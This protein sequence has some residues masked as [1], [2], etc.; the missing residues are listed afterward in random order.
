M[1]AY[2]NIRCRPGLVALGLA[3]LLPLVACGSRT[4]PPDMRHLPYRPVSSHDFGIP[5]QPPRRQGESQLW[6]D[7]DGDGY[8]EWFSS[9]EFRL[10]A[11]NPRLPIP[12]DYEWFPVP[13][14][15][16]LTRPALVMSGDFDLEGDGKRDIVAVAA[17]TVMEHF[18]VWVLDPATL[19]P[20]ADFLLDAP[21]GRFDD[22]HWDGGFVPLGGV[23][24]P[25]G[26]G[27]LIV[28]LV[29][30]RYDIE[31]RGVWAVDPRSGAI[32][33][34]YVT[35][36]LPSRIASTIA[37]L[38]GDGVPEIV[39][40][41]SAPGNLHGET[42]NGVSDDST[43]VF[44][45]NADGKE[46]WHHALMDRLAG[47]LVLIDD[48][49][50]DGETEVMVGGSHEVGVTGR[51]IMF[52]GN[53]GT[54]EYREELD[55]GVMRLAWLPRSDD[56]RARFAV[57]FHDGRLV[58]YQAVDGAYEP[59][60][61][62][63]FPT[64]IAQVLVSDVLGDGEPEITVLVSRRALV[65]LDLDL[66]PLAYV[67]VPTWP[68]RNEI[69]AWRMTPTDVRLLSGARPGE[70]IRFVAAPN[71]TPWAV[72]AAVSV[73]V[74]IGLA[75]QI[76]RNSRTSDDPVVVR[77]LRRQ[78]LDRLKILRHEK[79]GTLENLDRLVWY[80][81]AA[82]EAGSD[83]VA[84]LDA[85]RTLARDTQDTTLERLRGSVAIAERVGVPGHRVA[86]LAEACD[87][88]ETL[89][90]HVQRDLAVAEVSTALE[91]LGPLRQLL[92][93]QC[94]RLREVVE[95][96]FRVDLATVVADVLR[97]QAPTLADAGIAT[98]VQGEAVD[99]A[100]WQASTGPV[101]ICDPDDL[102]FI[103]DNLVG[104]AARA[105]QHMATRAL[106]LSWQVL[107]DAVLVHVSDTG[108]GIP[109]DD[110]DRV[111]AGD[112]TTR[113]GGG[114]GF[115]RTQESLRLFHGRLWI[116]SSRPGGGTVFVVRLT[117]ARGGAGEASAGLEVPRVRRKRPRQSSP[118][119]VLGGVVLLIAA[120][121]GVL[122]Y[123]AAH[124]RWTID[125]GTITAHGGVLGRT[126]W[127][128]EVGCKSARCMVAPWNHAE[129]LATWRDCDTDTSVVACLHRSTGEIIWTGRPD[130][131]ILDAA[132]GTEL[133][134]SG[135]MRAVGVYPC[136][137]DGDGESE[138]IAEFRHYP[139]FPDCL[140]RFDRHG[141]ALN[142]YVSSG[143]ILDIAITD[144][145]HDGKDEIIAAA[146]NNSP[147]Y[148][149]GS[150]FILDEDHFGGAAVDSLANPQTSVRDSAAYRIVVPHL[151]D[152]Y[153]ALIKEVRLGATNV[154]TFAGPSGDAEVSAEM[155]AT[156]DPTHRVFTY[157]DAALR[158]LRID[159]TDN[160]RAEVAALWPDSLQAHRG[161]ADPEWL[162]DWF[163]TSI[164]FVNG[165]MVPTT[166]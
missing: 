71:R 68:V 137:L 115:K 143:H 66:T 140:V 155:G 164:R 3:A 157:F 89:L 105:M 47:A 128:I 29:N 104:N 158:P 74:L 85:V 134:R 91:A 38:D 123:G 27:D 69:K 46:R 73:L 15:Y 144:I 126:L 90:T 64:N 97:A 93:L 11:R 102:G 133:V 145:D 118:F 60:H 153:M 139:Y 49:D 32:V 119:I 77:E 28:F 146:T 23:P 31:G 129:L 44:V 43:Y 142:Q 141:R 5:D 111:L 94:G 19:M 120:F 50:G 159:I 99:P 42:I 7:A 80:L 109:P 4:I 98:A 122:R 132:Y 110:W 62:R 45:V 124:A 30:S 40:G 131:S 14:P 36:A 59:V 116:E 87:E 148:R 12:L 92:T 52:D 103:I 25:D 95:S 156:H 125:G 35:G 56:G 37:D 9:Q 79:L 67:P 18:R 147:R 8:D 70:N 55:S 135:Q 63:R 86:S 150:L 96:A 48:F 20:K 112:G 113:T 84:A 17:D 161:P 75:W 58:E 83:D 121:L 2:R 101:V 149:G 33:W 54:E 53:T 151:P 152:P 22:G 166:P 100:T 154:K 88:L 6:F 130:V 10:A 162:D 16:H 65:V 108:R 114:F 127:G 34:R 165:Q 81:E 1:R 106:A 72:A 51:L 78:L 61:E 13:P 163:H 21:P 160:F 57:A 39:F 76:R 24:R 82:R 107:G 138:I 26:P 117:R 136:D 41:T